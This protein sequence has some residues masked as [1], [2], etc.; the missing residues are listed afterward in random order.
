MSAF[1]HHQLSQINS[2]PVVVFG[3][4]TCQNVDK[5]GGPDMP[6]ICY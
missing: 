4:M 2:S 3:V 5:M 1:Y 6:V